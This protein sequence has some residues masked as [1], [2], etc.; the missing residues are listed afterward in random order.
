MKKT[1]N[2]NNKISSFMKK[3]FLFTCMAVVALLMGACAEDEIV[4]S[5]GGNSVTFDVTIPELA[6]TRAVGDGLT[7][8]T[9]YWGVYDHNNVLLED[10]SNT[11]DSDHNVHGGQTFSKST[12]LT[13]TLAQD[14]NYSIIFWAAN[15]SNSMCT[16]DWEA[17]T[18]TVTPTKANQEAYDAFC[19]YEVIENVSGYMK[20]DVKLYR[21]FAQLNIGTADYDKAA[22]SGLTVENTQ[23]EI[24]GLP[25]AYDFVTGKA[26]GET[27][28]TYAYPDPAVDVRYDIDGDGNK[29]I[30]PVE[31]DKYDYLSM[32]YLL[33]GR[34][35]QNPKELVTVT[36]K[37]K[38]DDNQEHVRTYS[39]VPVQRNWRTNIYGN[40]LTSEADFTV[41]IMPEFADDKNE[42]DVHNIEVWDGKTTNAPVITQ[43]ENGE[44]IAVVSTGSQ[45]AYV[46][47]V[48]SGKTPSNA[49]A[50]RAGETVDYATMTIV[51]DAD[52]D[53]GNE[54]WLP[55]GTTSNPFKGT[56]DGN[57]FTIHNLK[58]TGYNSNVGLF[59]VTHD[60][61]IKNFILNNANVSGRL[62][63]GAVAGQPYTSKYTDITVK[64]HVEV[65]GM[66]YVG[67]VGGKDAYANWTNITVDVDATSFVKANSVE[68]GTAYRTY[69][70]GV[71]GFNGEGGHTF[72][73]IT[74]NINVEGS[75]LDVGGLFGIAHYGNKFE[76]CVCTG[77]VVNNIDKAEYALQTGGIAGVWNNGGE[78]VEFT[79]CSFKGTLSAPNAGDVNFYYNGL[80]G[81]P[82]SAAGPGKLIINGEVAVASVEALQAAID[83]AAEGETTI[84]LYADMVGDVTVVQKQG[85]KITIKGGDKKFNGSIKVHSNSN[86]YADAALTIQNVNFESSAASVNFIEALENGAQRYSTNITVDGCTFT[87]TGEGVN[88]SV[89]VQI[90]ASKNA[91]VL[92]CT[93]TGVHSLLQ[94]Q[95]CDET[96]VVTNCE[97]NGKNGVA[98]KQVKAATVEGTTITALE[99]GIRFDGNT[100]N[101]GITVKNNNVTAV[102]PLI[103][104][105]MTGKNNTI[106]LEGV[107]TF[108]TEADYQIVITNDSDDKPYVKPTGSYTLT[109]ADE[110]VV[111][112][113]N[114]VVAS[115]EE[116]AAAVKAGATKLR[117]KAGEYNVANCG[118]KTLEI[119]GSKDAIIMIYNEGEDGADYGFDGST[120]T[121]NGVTINTSKNTGNYKGFARMNATFN[122]CDFIGAYCSFH[123]QSFNNC[124]FDFKNGY[125]WTWGAT[126]LTFDACEFNGNSK[127]ILAHGSAATTININDCSFKASEKGYTGAGDNTAVVEMDPIANNRYTVNFTGNNTKT[128][129]YAG[130]YRVKDETTGHTV[131]GIN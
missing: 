25:T 40:I 30:F 27:T 47:Q 99:Y 35:P 15:A 24:A 71:V 13:L 72:K 49:P 55:V 12:K 115:S 57:G 95:S 129:H 109:G 39:S 29:E 2:N 114:M 69:V 104:R 20:R 86:F 58:V 5:Q 77:N 106:A 116:L 56:F 70:G 73:N 97:I 101:Y 26:S 91:K 88:T 67:G 92:N 120:V 63:V 46:A 53:L 19:S 122:D 105:K 52:L 119:N 62:N 110:Y 21:P 84:A 87:A 98:F 17:R 28:F 8:T 117:L 94:A 50:T 33:V 66:A 89:G 131:T 107:N 123:T 32:N 75:T 127:C 128:E 43:D 31:D 112:P 64:G 76:N 85:V 125:F 1:I 118:G 113:L 6:A 41:T 93:A 11:T 78:N 60:G 83:A 38:D 14:K 74:S 103:V 36:F 42:N 3:H 79:N 45:L 4:K 126:A 124:T 68:N 100:D 121:F 111:Y 44:E 54:E 23:V 18:M 65:N 51:L 96:V 102:Q 59:G 34:D 130:W 48:L 81:A 10:I 82:Y 16:V 22:A 9:L 90:K 37:Y 61:E 80:V 108:T 7:A